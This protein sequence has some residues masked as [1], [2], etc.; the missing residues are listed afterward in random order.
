[1]IQIYTTSD[2]EQLDDIVYRFY[3]ATSGYVEK[4]LEANRHL[5]DLGLVFNA[6]V[7]IKLPPIFEKKEKREISLWD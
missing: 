5:S 4:V 3:G 7:K 1:M 2:G 6:G